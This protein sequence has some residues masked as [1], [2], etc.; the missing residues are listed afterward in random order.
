MLLA[1]LTFSFPLSKTSH[2]ARGHSASSSCCHSTQFF[3]FWGTIQREALILLSQPLLSLS[4]QR[5]HTSHSSMVCWILEGDL[6]QAQGILPVIPGMLFSAPRALMLKNVLWIS[7]R[8]VWKLGLNVTTQTSKNRIHLQLD[9][10]EMSKNSKKL[11]DQEKRMV[12]A[13]Q[14]IELISGLSLCCLV[15]NLT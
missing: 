10:I 11:E 15:G 4:W 8:S 14:I 5:E 13:P 2:L 12:G 3:W 7:S 9:N 1:T 6:L